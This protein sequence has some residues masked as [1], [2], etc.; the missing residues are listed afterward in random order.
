MKLRTLQIVLAFSI[1]FISVSAF[2]Y[3]CEAV[4]EEAKVRCEPNRKQRY[5]WYYDC[6]RQAT[7]DVAQACTSAVALESLQI[8][9]RRKTD[10]IESTLKEAAVEA[11]EPARVAL[12]INNH[13]LALVNEVIARNG[14]EL[15]DLKEKASEAIR[16][17]HGGGLDIVSRYEVD[18]KDVVNSVNAAD[19]FRELV[20]TIRNAE[21]VN[22]AAISAIDDHLDSVIAV[23]SAIN[24]LE[25]RMLSELS[26]I[27]ASI[28]ADQ[29][30]WRLGESSRA[31]DLSIRWLTSVKSELFE[32]TKKVTSTIDQKILVVKA[33]EINDKTE[34]QLRTASTLA[35]SSNYLRDVQ[36]VVNQMGQN[37]RSSYNNLPYLSNTLEY[38]SKLQ[39]FIRFCSSGAVSEWQETGCN[40]ALSY[41]GNADRILNSTTLS[42]L[43]FG[44][45]VFA[46]SGHSQV[47]VLNLQLMD[48]ISEGDI[49]GAVS[50]YDTILF[51]LEG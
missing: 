33:R 26:G 10:E 43:N 6:Y 34:E 50:I 27:S 9:V 23:R 11:E 25:A 44:A 12:A 17:A 13:R 18:I 22:S 37:R 46:Q 45:F 38:A 31:V 21:Q 5:K 20:K 28:P 41:Q 32:S 24:S 30:Q 29:V 47:E 49:D 1:S 40:R 15:S 14:R 4:L 7:I 42:A 3:Q 35:L 39:E 36:F 51:M 8:E 19:D 16:F 2:T 48:K